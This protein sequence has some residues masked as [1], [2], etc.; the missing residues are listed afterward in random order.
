MSIAKRLILFCMGMGCW[1]PTHLLAGD[2]V[3][4]GPLFERFDLTLAPGERTEAVSPFYYSEESE[5]RHTWAIPPLTL[6]YE[7]DP[8]AENEEFDF[9]YPI[10]TY[11]R[12][13]TEYRFQICQVFSFAGGDDQRGD[14]ARRF[15]LFPIYFQQRS[16]DPE[17][18]YTAFVPFYGTLKQRLFRD[19]IHFVLFPCYA[20]TRK[21][22][23]ITYDTPYPLFS[24]SYG[25]GLRGWQVWPLVG[26]EHK[27]VT[28]RTNGFNDLETVPGHDSRFVLW[29]FFLQNNSQIGTDN[30]VHEQDMIPFYTL[31]R[32][33]LRDSTTYFWPLG[34]THTL[35]R[36]KHFEEWAAP[37][38]FI[39]FDRGAGK[40]TSRVWPLFSQ[41]TN[42]F[43][44][45]DWYLWPVYKYN[46]IHVS[47]LDHRRTRILFFL[48][49]D[50]REKNTETLESMRRVDFL[51]FF[52]H[53]R[54]FNGNERLQILSIIEPFLPGSHKVERDY[55][56]LYALWRAER[57]AKTGATSQSLLWNL[58]RHE[59][60]PQTRKTSLL[61]GLFRYESSPTGRRWRVCYVT[62]G[63]PKTVPAG[64][65][66]QSN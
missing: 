41:S 35:E 26:H 66:G 50:L 23:V 61:F 8:A 13:G 63:R 37:W 28:T 43:L 14:L 49:S 1:I 57:N 25:I 45:S 58:Y 3:S 22:D 29:P 15:T 34:V 48:Y 53:H 59:A 31:Y 60:T 27:D 55:S 4:A 7:K 21:A 56:H 62:F 51:P 9:A 33:K 65:A 2:P 30:P 36:E 64:S 46:G 18:D 11:D 32:S 54:D 16:P 24:R 20:R 47:A 17:K 39:V 5:G 6:S 44:E 10:L 19:E 38:P 12:F 52:T 40:R 42:Q